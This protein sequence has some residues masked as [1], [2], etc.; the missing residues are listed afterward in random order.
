MN[1]DKTDNPSPAE[2][3]HPSAQ[4]RGDVDEQEASA[5]KPSTA[6]KLAPVLK[7]ILHQTSV[8]LKVW[9]PFLKNAHDRDREIVFAARE[10]RQAARWMIVLPQQ[11]WC[12]GSKENL[13]RKKHDTLVRGFEYPIPIFVTM[14]TAVGF[15]LLVAWWLESWFSVF[16]A[17]FIAAAGLAVLYLK[18]WQDRVQITIWAT[19]EHASEPYELDLAVDEADLY[20]YVPSA[21]LAADARKAVKAARRTYAGTMG[22]RPG[23]AAAPMRA[24]QDKQE[25]KQATV[26]I[27]PPQQPVELPAI[28]LE[29]EDD[30][31]PNDISQSKRKDDEDPLPLPSPDE[32]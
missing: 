32:F 9:I 22:N 14:L 30:P 27:P 11:C 31:D 12:C 28:K 13:K 5:G 15:L 17:M 25:P 3:S 29:G 2:D 10:S 24:E 7:P 6:S 20:V 21:E 26:V 16:L 23:T 19:K 18:S 1:D 4:D 8:N